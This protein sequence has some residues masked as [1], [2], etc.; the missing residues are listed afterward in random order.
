MRESWTR[1]LPLLSPAAAAVQL[2]V[3]AAIPH[4]RVTGFRVLTG[5]LANTNLR[6]DLEGDDRVLLRLYQR[7][8]AQ[9]AKERALHE[10]VRVRVPVPRFLHTGNRD[11]QVFA[12]LEWMEG[13]RLDAYAGNE[14]LRIARDV[15]RR[16]AEIHAFTFPIAGDLGPDLGITQAWPMGGACVDAFIDALLPG[17]AEQRLGADAVTRLR[18]AVRR[19]APLLDAWSSPPR[20]VH[21]DFGPTNILVDAKGVTAVLDWEF[22]VAHMP[23]A[24]FG[25]LLRPPL[26]RREGFADAVADGYRAAGGW[27][28]KHWR[29]AA[30]L[31]DC[32]A[33]IEFLSRDDPGEAVIATAKARL[34]EW[35]VR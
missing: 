28:P 10:L 18:T 2:M 26:G 1:R 22:A 19:E 31:M 30:A 5:G 12:V 14:L 9:M 34:E 27:L 35:V 32:F 15:G 29:E 3:Q 7:D 11:G 25:N 13:D 6:V 16:L 24:D 20:L 21:C 33:W 4:T 23:P 8:P 17:R